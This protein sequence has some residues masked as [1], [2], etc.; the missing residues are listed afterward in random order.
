[1]STGKAVNHN[2]KC[3]DRFE[4][5]FRNNGDAR[6]LRQAERMYI[7]PEDSGTAS[8][9]AS[10]PMRSEQEDADM[11]QADDMEDGSSQGG[12]EDENRMLMS[13]CPDE[14]V[15]RRIWKTWHDIEATKRRKSFH[16]GC[17]CGE[18]I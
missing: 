12:M 7:E 14:T 1:M 16:S 17:S 6:L 9:S 18:Q 3:R 5:L 8:G 2:E 15:Q 11:E 4:D 10:P 13:L